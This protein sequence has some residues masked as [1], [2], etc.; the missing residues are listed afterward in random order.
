MDGRKVGR[1]EGKVFVR[2]TCK[3]TL[4]FHILPSKTD[5]RVPICEMPKVTFHPSCVSQPGTRKLCRQ[6][7][8]E[9]QR[10]GVIRRPCSC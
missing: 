2:L 1:G 6:E 4:K 8:R 7:E 10:Q 3:A 5:D 9:E